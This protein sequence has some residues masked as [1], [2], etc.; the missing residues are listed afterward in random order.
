VSDLLD[1]EE[2]KIPHTQGHLTEGYR[3]RLERNTMVVP[4]M[5]D[6]EPIAFGVAK[7]LE[8]ASF[9]HAKTFDDIDPKYFRGKHTL[10]L[11]HS[12]IN[13][14]ASIVDFM[15]PLREKHPVLQV[16]VVASI[17]NKGALADGNL[18]EMLMIGRN[19]S[20]IT[21]RTSKKSYVGTKGTDT[22]HRLFNTIELD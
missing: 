1:I 21:L 20:I 10:I 4:L 22:G 3:L 9:V 7:A 19:L 18:A 8:T 11:V 13:S 15:K 12:V 5:R 14:G 2:F 6:G 17:V 16:V